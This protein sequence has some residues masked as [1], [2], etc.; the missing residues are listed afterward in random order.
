MVTT[1]NIASSTTNEK[2]CV[3][4]TARLPGTL[5]LAKDLLEGCETGENAS[6][7]FFSSR[8]TACILYGFQDIWTSFTDKQVTQQRDVRSYLEPSHNGLQ[9]TPY[10]MVPRRSQEL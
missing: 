3:L 1:H 5:E 6:P 7:L 10:Y 9:I 2:C 4:H 8:A